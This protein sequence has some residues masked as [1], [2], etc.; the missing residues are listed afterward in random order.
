MIDLSV[1]RKV[2]VNRE[3]NRQVASIIHMEEKKYLVR[4]GSVIIQNIGQLLPHQIATGRFNTGDFI[5]PV[6]TTHIVGCK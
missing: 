6:S 5:Y 3:E 2:Y 1:Y 4:V